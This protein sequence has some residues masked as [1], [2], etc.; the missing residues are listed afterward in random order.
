MGDRNSENSKQAVASMETD[1]TSRGTGDTAN[2]GDSG[3]VETWPYGYSGDSGDGDLSLVTHMHITRS[4]KQT[5]HET[6]YSRDRKSRRK[7]HR[8]LCGTFEKP[9]KAIQLVQKFFSQGNTSP[10]D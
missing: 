9:S 7:I 6:F 5:T 1:L 2:N 3:P 10:F 4:H 8:I